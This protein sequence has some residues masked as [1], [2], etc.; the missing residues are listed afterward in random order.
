MWNELPL[1]S[2]CVTQDTWTR[3]RGRRAGVAERAYCPDDE[4]GR[5]ANEFGLSAGELRDLVAEVP[6]AADLLQHCLRALGVT[7]ADVV[8][9]A[10]KQG[11]ERG[12]H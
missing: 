1:L 12:S 3:W 9:F 11:L 2:G 10:V 7:P 5:I 4:I 6:G 8:L